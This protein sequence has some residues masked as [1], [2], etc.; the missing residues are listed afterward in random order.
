MIFQTKCQPHEALAPKQVDL[1]VSPALVKAM[2][3]AQKTKADRSLFQAYM[4]GCSSAPNA[5]EISGIFRFFLTLRP[6]CARQLSLSMECLRFIER[7]SLHHTYAEQFSHIM[8]W[9]DTMLCAVLAKSRSQKI[10]D[11]QF[12]DLNM[13]FLVLILPIVPLKRVLACKGPLLQVH[14]SLL[15]TVADT[16]L[17][18]ELFQSA[19]SQVLAEQVGQ[20]ITTHIVAALKPGK[21]TTMAQWQS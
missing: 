5:T 9:V 6:G 21:V 15:K 1:L 7:L 18:K 12:I 13:D 8:G 14:D 11:K 10:S 17:G 3:A 19:M 4:A 16:T 20:R 2:L